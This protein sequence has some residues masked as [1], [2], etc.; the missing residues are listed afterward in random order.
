MFPRHSTDQLAAVLPDPHHP[1]TPV[2]AG[3]SVECFGLAGGEPGSN[4]T[5][6][7]ADEGQ[8]LWGRVA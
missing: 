5:G 4:V 1:T 8:G 7:M 6:R 3:W 2:V